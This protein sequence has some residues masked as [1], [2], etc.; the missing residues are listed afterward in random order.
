MNATILY[1]T[2]LHHSYASRDLIGVFTSRRSLYK[3]IKRII[4]ENQW[5]NPRE[6]DTKAELKN[7]IDWNIGFFM[8]KG[9]TQGLNEFELDTNKIELN[10][11][12]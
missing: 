12:L 11:L 1:K 8:E 5:D 9:Q 2:D 10:K 3:C 7:Y 4:K 6:L